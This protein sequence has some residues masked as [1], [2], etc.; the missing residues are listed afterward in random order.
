MPLKRKLLA[1]GIAILIIAIAIFYLE[2]SKAPNSS[3]TEINGIATWVNSEPL[4]IGSLKG[5]VVLI[6]FWTYSCNSCIRT[7]PYLKAWHDKYSS[8]GLVIIGVH[9]PEF[10]FEK[11]P[12]NVRDAV[13]RF[14]LQ[15][16]VAMDNDF[17]TWRAFGNRF[18]P[19]KYLFDA[20]GNLRYQHSG[21]GAYNATEST[22]RELLKEIGED[23]SRIPLEGEDAHVDRFLGSSRPFGMTREIFA[24]GDTINAIEFAHNVGITKNYQDDGKHEVAGIYIGGEWKTEADSMAH[25]G[26]KGYLTIVYWG[27]VATPVMGS[28]SGRMIAKVLLDGKDVPKEYAGRDLQVDALGNSIVEVS[29]P[30][31][32]YSLVNVNIPYGKHELRLDVDG[33]FAIWSVTFGG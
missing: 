31:R 32:L 2:S 5:K 4:T 15:Y 8:H 7:F 10:S 23:L 21:E 33:Q 27:N 12:D 9:S 28:T 3:G 11:N 19:T 17:A 13:K 29:G 14:G 30:P 24:V 26:K 6:D 22:I 25:V 16:P 18:W 20:N 1:S